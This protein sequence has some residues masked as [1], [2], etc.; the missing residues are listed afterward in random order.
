MSTLGLR[1]DSAHDWKQA[2]GGQSAWLMLASDEAERSLRRFNLRPFPILG[3]VAHVR[4]T[5][6]WRLCRSCSA[7]IKASVDAK[8]FSCARTHDME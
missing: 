2:S 5:H 3:R 7:A 8:S 1:F 6:T 4:S